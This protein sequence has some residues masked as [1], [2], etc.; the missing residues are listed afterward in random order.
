MKMNDKLLMNL[1]NMMLYSDFH[2][3]N[4]IWEAIQT[5]KDQEKEICR[6]EEKVFEMKTKEG[7]NENE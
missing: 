1:N 7:E 3:V 5:I 4:V 2:D 6:L